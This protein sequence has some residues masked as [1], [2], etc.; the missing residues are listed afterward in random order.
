MMVICHV[1]GGAYLISELPLCCSGDWRF[2]L[3]IRLKM[4]NKHE[5]EKLV[6]VRT[7]F[8]EALGRIYALYGL[9]DVFGRIYGVLFLSDRPLGLEDIAEELG[10]SKSTVSNNIRILEG[11]GNAR[12]VWVKGSRRDYYEAERNM[13]KIAIET[14]QK[15]YEK[16]LEIVVNAS[17]SCKNLLADI[18]DSSDKAIR[19]KALFYY[20]H[21]DNMEGQSKRFGRT[22]A[23]L[24]ISVF[25]EEAKK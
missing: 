17:E 2:G 22:L 1:E 3:G 10:V 24:L 14:I 9:P 20:R 18:S 8:I 5:Q 25:Q 12:K 16:E 6:E 15:N 19:E 4:Q 7:T 11:V 13:A 21:I 23:E